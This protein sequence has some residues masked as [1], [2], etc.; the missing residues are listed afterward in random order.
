MPPPLPFPGRVA[1]SQP[2]PRAWSRLPTARSDPRP[3]PH[4]SSLLAHRLCTQ[5]PEDGWHGP[6]DSDQLVGYKGPPPGGRLEVFIVCA[7]RR[8]S[9]NFCFGRLRLRTAGVPVVDKNL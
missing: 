6:A 1:L 2:P 4:S 3:A 7:L 9:F 8:Q 5:S